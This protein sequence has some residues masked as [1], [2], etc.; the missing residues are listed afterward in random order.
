MNEASTEMPGVRC[1]FNTVYL[2]LKTVKYRHGQSTESGEK[3]QN[4]SATYVVKD[5][6]VGAIEEVT[7]EADTIQEPEVKTVTLNSL[8]MFIRD[9]GVIHYYTDLETYETLLFVLRHQ[10]LK[11]MC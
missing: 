11:C 3:V 5:T 2:E 1:H 10:D 9:N 7:A 8:R 4:N 6:E